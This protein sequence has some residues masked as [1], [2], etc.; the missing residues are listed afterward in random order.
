MKNAV[1]EKDKQI[2]TLEL[3]ESQ[4]EGQYYQVNNKIHKNAF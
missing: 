3:L 2:K 1:Y 4:L